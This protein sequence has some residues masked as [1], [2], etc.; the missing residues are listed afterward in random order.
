MSW[1]LEGPSGEMLGSY[2]D[3]HKRAEERRLKREEGA[4]ATATW[5]FSP[6]RVLAGWG[7]AS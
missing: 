3:Q 2:C 1:T 6:G 7:V 4:L 5:W